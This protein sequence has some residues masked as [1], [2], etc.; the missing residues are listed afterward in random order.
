VRTVR[1]TIT[2]QVQGVGFRVF[3]DRT[4]RVAGASGW[5][6]NRRS[7]AVEALVSVEDVE[8]LIATLR[9]GPGRVDDIQVEEVNEPQ[10]GP[11]TIAPTV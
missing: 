7:G 2:G 11:F 5:V 1:V 9:D 8:G 4:A 3:V 6:R 10:R